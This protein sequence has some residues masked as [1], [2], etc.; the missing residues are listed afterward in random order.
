MGTDITARIGYIVLE[1][2]THSV[3]E[4][5]ASIGLSEREPRLP[6]RRG[7]VEGKSPGHHWV[8]PSLDCRRKRK[9]KTRKLE[10][11]SEAGA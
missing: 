4:A 6:L 5:A 7:K 9:R 10:W 11:R 3:I 8:V 2:D 1:G